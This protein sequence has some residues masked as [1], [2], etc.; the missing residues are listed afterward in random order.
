MV[1]ESAATMLSMTIFEST[2]TVVADESNL[3]LG[4]QSR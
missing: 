4:R 3:K 2:V 1:S